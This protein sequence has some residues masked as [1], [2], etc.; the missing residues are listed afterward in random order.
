MLLQL[1][2]TVGGAILCQ[3]GVTH[4]QTS[5]VALR[6]QA[7]SPLSFAAAQTRAAIFPP[8]RATSE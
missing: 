1:T 7:A 3:S 2:A 5:A 4:L 8:R 6:W